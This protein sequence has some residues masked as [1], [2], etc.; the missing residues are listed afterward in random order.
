MLLGAHMPVAGGL[1]TAFEMGQTVGCQTM[2]IFTKNQRQW[3]V[4]PLTEAELAT[5]QTARAA[6]QIEPIITHDSYLINLAS[7]IEEAWEKSVAAFRDEIERNTLL[8]I[9]YLVTHAGAHMKSGEEAGLTRIAQAVNR[10][11][12]EI[13]EETGRAPGTLILF[14]TTAGQGTALGYKFEHWAQL[15]EMLDHPEWVGICFDTC[16]V[17]ASGYDFTTSEGY[18][19]TMGDFDRLIGTER[20]KA[21]HINDSQKGLGSRVDRHEAIGKGMMG[22]EPFRFLLND[23][24]FEDVPKVLETPKG[25][26]CKEDIE[27]LAMLRS[28]IGTL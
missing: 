18:T 16:H 27:N 9:P 10:I 19:A 2:Q 23:S 4:K 20:I 21:F 28:L 14:E 15:L 12:A 6:H 17:F 7:P 5:W 1:Q 8:N 25:P 24:R 3:K 22:L 11:H 13:S 26:D